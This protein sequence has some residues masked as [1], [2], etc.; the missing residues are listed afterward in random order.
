MD[1]F[2]RFAASVDP[3]DRTTL[4]DVRE[5]AGWQTALHRAEFTPAGTD[6]VDIRTYLL[7]LRAR[8]ADHTAIR[9]VVASLKRLYAWSQAQGLIATDPFE[10][11]NFDRPIRTR[12]EIRRRE[13]AIADP[14][15][16][17]IERLRALNRIAGEL[18]GT[19]DTQTM[20]QKT[21]ETVLSV[22]GLRTAWAFLLTDSGLTAFLTFTPPHDFALAAAVGLPPGLEREERRF[23]CQAPDCHCQ[24]Y[25]R[26]NRLTRAVNIVECSRLE[27]AAAAAGEQGVG[28]NAGL[29]YH[30]SVPL[31][32]Q[33]RPVGIL[34]FATEEYQLF[35]AADLELLSA[36]GAQ[37]STALERARLYDI[38]EI[39]RAR[40]AVELEMARGV[41]QSL[42]PESLPQ[43]PGFSLAA[44][45]WCAREVGGDFY[46]V[47]PLPENRWGILVGDVSDKG[48]P[49]A[50]YMAMTR[51]LI[52]ARADYTA[53]PANLLMQV[54]HALVTQSSSDMFVTAFY[55][56]LD[57]TARTLTYANAGHNPPI[58]RRG[59]AESRE[60]DRTGIALGAFDDRTVSETAVALARGDALVI[61]TDGVTE[62]EN[63]H[64]EE[65]SPARLLAAVAAA[66]LPAAALLESVVNNWRS[67]TQGVEPSD[68]TT[69]LALT[70][71]SE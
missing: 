52:R 15:T 65:Y 63:R 70:C 10:K 25:L 50:L 44:H 31:T 39:Q 45:W 33:G 35:N 12:D 61:Y 53:S 68:D 69:I 71:D 56:I 62:A 22:M 5:Y 6:D 48:A 66:P 13:V 54:N 3:A 11:Y 42:V 47:F 67:F 60:L 46:D 23:L 18:N 17:E 7:D 40:L 16:R 14:Q 21:L 43:I 24:S 59:Q 1:F 49:A 28:A 57:P 34:N 30:A 26:A 20:L 2:E 4:A 51:G 8:G 19:L 29:L 36:V 38:A 64:A 58:L 27:D 9:H 41:Q 55:A 32:L 37:V